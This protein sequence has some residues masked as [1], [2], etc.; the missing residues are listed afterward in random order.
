MILVYRLDFD[1]RTIERRRLT[2]AGGTGDQNDPVRQLD[3][4]V[5]L[6]IQAGLH[7]QLTQIKLHSPFIKQ[8]H[9]DAFAVDHWNDR[10]TNVDI[11]AGNLKLDTAVLRQPLFGDVQPSHNLQTTNDR[12]LK[13][14]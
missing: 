5:K 2:G 3:Q 13:S 9:H 8:P 1:Q 7:A 12:Q 14:R 6:L 11:A 10:H 4:F